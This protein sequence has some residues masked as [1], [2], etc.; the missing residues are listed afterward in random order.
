MAQQRVR[1]LSTQNV[2]YLDIWAYNDLIW[3]V[4]ARS[5]YNWTINHMQKGLTLWLNWH[6]YKITIFDQAGMFICRMQWYLCI[7]NMFCLFG[8]PMPQKCACLFNRKGVRDWEKWWWVTRSCYT[9]WTERE[10]EI[11][12]GKD[13]WAQL[14]KL[15][16]L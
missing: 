5:I 8:S 3:F 1:K 14:D 4:G 6:W 7:W 12:R 9:A 13:E 2:Q 15:N 10:Y 11:E 16:N